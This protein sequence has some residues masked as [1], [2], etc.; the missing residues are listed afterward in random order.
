MTRSFD[1]DADALPEVVRNEKN[2]SSWEDRQRCQMGPLL[3]C[4][5]PVS[6]HLV[7]Y[8]SRDLELVLDP[9]ALDV[10]AIQRAGSPKADSP[11]AFL[12]VVVQADV[13]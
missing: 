3:A 5:L 8:L 12:E 6:S 1:E 10:V 11:K 4:S 7:S 9:E 13:L 2:L